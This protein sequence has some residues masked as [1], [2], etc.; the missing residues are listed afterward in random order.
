VRAL[1][2]AYKTEKADE[3]KKELMRKL[4]DKEKVKV[5]Y[6]PLFMECTVGSEEYEYILMHLEKFQ[7]N[8]GKEKIDQ[9]LKEA[10]NATLQK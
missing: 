5:E 3:V 8:I 2:E 1:R 4:S 10:Y 6:W 7:K 9:F